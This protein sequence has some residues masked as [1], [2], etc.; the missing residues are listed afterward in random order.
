MKPEKPQTLLP[1]ATIEASSDFLQ[2]KFVDSLTV[3]TNL[4]ER[5]VSI[6]ESK[7]RICLMNYLQN[8]K[9]R[10]EWITPLGLSIT[11]LITLLTTDFQDRFSIPKDTW[12][13]IFV[14][15]GVISFVWLIRSLIKLP[16]E[17]TIDNIIDE[18][19][20]SLDSTKIVTKK[21]K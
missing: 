5:V 17:V 18:L 10:G 2:K 19:I 3:H 6:S 15:C 8:L 7:I 21:L 1:K 11:I 12:Q 9:E 20:P 13:A 4:G 16:K 14:I